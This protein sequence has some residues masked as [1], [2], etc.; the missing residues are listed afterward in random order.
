MLDT[1]W[2]CLLLFTGLCL[3]I[4]VYVFLFVFVYFDD[5]QLLYGLHVCIA[6]CATS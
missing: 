2:S 5:S 4:C 1:C 6:S 3:R